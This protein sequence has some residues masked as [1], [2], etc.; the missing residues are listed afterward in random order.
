MT[1]F[2]ITF[3]G[4]SL[5]FL[6]FFVLGVFVLGYTYYTRRGSGISQHPYGDIDHQSGPETPSELA[7]DVTQDIHNWDH[8]VAGR[9]RRRPPP[10]RRV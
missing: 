10:R 2:A 9:H 3:A 5:I 1:G 6:G 4:G 7:H 8:G